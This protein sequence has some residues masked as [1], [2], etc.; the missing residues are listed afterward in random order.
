MQ[1]LLK[2]TVYSLF[3]FAFSSNLLSKDVPTDLSEWKDWVSYKQEFQHCPYLAG[4]DSTKK[5]NHL[6]AWPSS[7]KL[8]VNDKQLKFSQD[9]S[10]LDE[11]KIPLPGNINHWPQRVKVNYK[12]AVVLKINNK[13]YIQLKEGQYQFTGIIPWVKRPESIQIPSQ[14]ALID[15]KVD[16]KK[17]EFIKRKSSQLWLGSVKKIEKEEV[18]FLKVWVNRLIK[19][20]HPMTMTIALDLDIGGR[21]REEVLTKINL[22][23]YQLMSISSALN[24]QIDSQ[25]NL[26]IQLKPGSFEVRLRFK[27][28]G[29]PNE[30]DFSEFGQYWPKQEIW[31]YQNNDRLRS[32]Q[33]MD[34]SAIDSEQGFVNSWSSLPHYVVNH[35]EIFKI[36]EGHR[37]IS[38]SSDRLNLQR[39]MWLS[40]DNETYYFFDTIKGNKSKDWRL[41]T[42]PEYKLTQLKNHNKERLITYSKN[43]EDVQVTGVEVRTHTIDVFAGGEVASNKMN[44]ASGWDINFTTTKI[45]LSIPPGRKLIA[46]S[47]ADS[48][49]GDWLGKWNLIDLF[50]VLIITAMAFKFF[51]LLASLFALIT[52]V[53]G[54]HESNMPTFLWLN[55]IAA[56]SVVDKVTKPNWLKAFNIYRWISVGLLLLNLL[57]FIAQQIRFTLH[58]QLEM[59]HSISNYYNS[60]NTSFFAPK[61]VPNIAMEESDIRQRK[62]AKSVVSKLKLNDS[63]S[64]KVIITGSRLQRSDLDN[65]YEQGAIIQAGKGKPNWRWKQAGYGWNGP[66]EGDEQVGLHILTTNWVRLL[67]VMLIVFSLLW[68]L[69]ILNKGFNIKNK[70][71]KMLEE[72]KN[73]TIANTASI[74]MAI[75]LGISSLS[76]SEKLSA[77]DYPSEALLTELH[78]RLYPKPL[79]AP[80][81]V[82]VANAK[83]S[84][85]G[86][87]VAVELEYQSGADLASLLPES[88]DWNIEAI[89][90]NGKATKALWKNKSG[91]WLSLKSGL[92]KVKIIARLKVKSDLM[93]RFPEK[94]LKLTHKIK[95]WELSGVSNRKISGSSVQLTR[96]APT[97]KVNSNN[98][99]TEAKRLA[100][101]PYEQSIADLFLLTR[102]FHFGSQWSLTTEV[103]RQAPQKGA[104]TTKIP[105]LSFEHPLQ[106]TD[107]IKNGLMHIVLPNNTY[108][109]SWESIIKSDSKNDES[110]ETFELTALNDPSISESWE[111]LV[112]PNWNIEISG[113]PAVFPNS[114]SP[115]DYWIYQYYPRAGE[116]LTFKLTKPPAV[117]GESIAITKISQSH[118]IS[119]RKTTTKL[120]IDYQ[121]T[122]AEPLIIDIGEHQ[123]KSVK[124]DQSKINLTKV[125]GKITIGLKPG[126][127]QVEII[128]EAPITVDFKRVI[129]SIKLERD[130]SNLTSQVN[131]PDSRWLLSASGAGYGPAILYWGELIFFLLL[132]IGLSRLSFSPLNYWQ[133]LILGLGMSTFSWPALALVAIW[134]LA[135]QWKR[136][137]KNSITKYAVLGNW[138][139]VIS[140]VFAVLALVGAVPFGLLQSPDMGVAGNGSYGNSLIWFLDQ[141]NDSLGNI[142]LYTLPLW[143]YKVL[144][145]LWATWLSFSLIKWLSWILKDLT[146]AKFKKEKEVK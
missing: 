98:I 108:S 59:S 130:F 104:L 29:F 48:S 102:R 133:W 20:G 34:A 145:L 45:N 28:H 84:V 124:Q 137:N 136:E 105:L 16:Q 61:P 33:I 15:L 25:G 123:I 116:K 83:I 106:N 19:D 70:M 143:I 103:T 21:A 129:K 134:L 40:F 76:V 110:S 95:G 139:T 5:Q 146:D 10:L 75:F 131:L 89:S 117:L 32:T 4:Q 63:Y 31:V 79:C 67:R 125:D 57:P 13:P 14:V 68:L 88:D 12:D 132:A 101:Q 51:G 112:F 27:I 46:I 18:D 111:I 120:Q 78:N 54:Y 97:V 73:K 39:Q 38:H 126:K 92:S 144:M 55:L 93:I 86:Q 94:P 127:H 72:P 41:N 115:D 64:E 35:Q 107:K 87:A 69:T 121:A 100:N 11:G 65:S 113:I 66:V 58:P 60:G 140:T 96:L 36:K 99:S 42:L 30:I 3:I 9:W 119:K 26:K 62:M 52:L 22:D 8:E 1:S 23:K 118:E 81:C 50:F 37:G 53:L 85:D 43:S 80:N 49:Y 82:S 109:S 122:R 77:K 6:C 47:G 74:G 7:L 114:Y 17:I 142:V 2:L 138:L 91:Q 128:I 90:V 44:H 24:T 71:K 141:G 135:S 56:I